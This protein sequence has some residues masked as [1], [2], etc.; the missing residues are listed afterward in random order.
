VA[1]LGIGELPAA[2]PE[3]RMPPARRASM[4][5]STAS[6][7]SCTATAFSCTCAFSAAGSRPAIGPNVAVPALAHSTEISRSASSAQNRSRAGGSARSTARTSTA[8]R[9]LSRRR[10]ATSLSTFSR[11][12]VMISAWPRAA[13]SVASASP[14][15]WDAPVTTA[16]ASGLGAG[17]GMG[18]S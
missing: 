5:G 14:I 17:T 2:E 8:T 4:P 11:R 7:R 18:Q 9:Y 1:L 3:I 10:A 6:T 15:P 12:A 16:R 13:S